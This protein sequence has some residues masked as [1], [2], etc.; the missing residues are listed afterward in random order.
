MKRRIYPILVVMLFGGVLSAQAQKANTV[1][2]RNM[3]LAELMNL[4]VATEDIRYM[5]LAELMEIEIE[6]VDIRDMDLAEL[7]EIEIDTA[8]EETENPSDVPFEASNIK[9]GEIKIQMSR[10]TL[11]PGA[12]AHDDATTN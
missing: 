3:S 9:K 10:R 5:D 7:M 12:N 6:T 8:S 1:D 4:E 11:S 2:I